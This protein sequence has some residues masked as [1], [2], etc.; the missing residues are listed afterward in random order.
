MTG[1]APPPPVESRI[2]W[3]VLLRALVALIR[4]YTWFTRGATLLLIA[5][6]I[7]NMAVAAAGDGAC[8]IGPLCWMPGWLQRVVASDG[9]LTLLTLAIALGVGVHLKVR[10]S[11]G[12]LDASDHY[13][14]GRA[15]AYG[16][17]A[18][19][20]VAAL[21]L[22]RNES[23]RLQLP[24]GQELKLWMVFP[25]NVQELDQ[26]IAKVE[27]S[28]RQR[29]GKR[30]LEGAYR[31]GGTLIRRSILVISRAQPE[32]AA[33]LFF[34]FPTTLYTLHDYYQSWN[35]WQRENRRTLMEED[36]IDALEQAQ[37]NT[38]L[39]H[40]RD[41]SRSSAGL[42]AVRH[43]GLTG[44]DLSQLFENHFEHVHPDR[45][46]ALFG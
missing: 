21:V 24:P 2:G 20:L 40:L 19:F 29:A 34:D 13:D 33:P 38:F 36:Q 11:K 3:P 42:H 35:T 41:L 25:G 16:Y 8:W 39:K 45:M 43:M 12:L 14:I 44:D 22:V 1:K 31:T 37:I 46:E 23:V 28:I 27:P 18:N 9:A 26:F 17:F 4:E 30:D 6:A 32:E 15:L 10:M 5:A 7:V